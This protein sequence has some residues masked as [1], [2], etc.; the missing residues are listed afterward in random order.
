MLVFK[1][2]LISSILAFVSPSGAQKTISCDKEMLSIES[3]ILFLFFSVDPQAA[4]A[5]LLM[6][7]I[8]VEANPDYLDIAASIDKSSSEP[9]A[10]VAIDLKKTVADFLIKVSLSAEIAGEFKEIYPAKDFNPCNKDE[11]EDEFVLYAL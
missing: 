1:F 8:T 2:V 7:D 10:N 5:K 3:A 9:V 4:E 6:D 11:V